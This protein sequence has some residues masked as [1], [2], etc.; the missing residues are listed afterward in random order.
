MDSK[1]F[2]VFISKLFIPQT[3]QIPGPK[4]LFLDGHGLHLN[5]DNINLC[6]ENNIYLYCLPPHTTHIFQP[7]GVVIFQ[8]VKAHFNKITQHLKLATTLGWS[9][10]IN[11]QK[12]NFTRIF[13]AS[14]TVALIKK[15]F[16]KCGILPLD[17]GAIDKSCLSGKSAI[18]NSSRQQSAIS[19]NP[20]QQLP[21]T[22]NFLFQRK[23][24]HPQRQCTATHLWQLES[25]LQ[26]YIIHLSSQK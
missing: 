14:I 6:R 3:T 18:T 20:N 11:C 17:R 10:P 23:I 5:T 22:N 15:G 13:R 26:I 19:S 9:N 1:L 16:Q 8:P 21:L 12:I 2:Y 7:L 4:L 24:K 25:S